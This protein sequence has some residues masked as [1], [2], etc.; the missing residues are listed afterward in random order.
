MSV[1]YRRDPERGFR[2]WH[3]N[4]VFTGEN[5][6][7]SDDLYVPNVYDVVFDG[8]NGFFRVDAVDPV[9]AVPT[10]VRFNPA[11]RFDNAVDEP[12]NLHE[13]LRLYQPHI[14]TRLFIN[15]STKPYTLSFDSRYRVYGSENTTVKLFLGTD[16]SKNGTVV[17]QTINSNGAVLSEVVDLVPLIQ[18]EVARKR[19]ARCHTT[20]DLQDGE[21]VTAVIYNAVGYASGEHSFIVRN[22]ATIAGPTVSNVYI[23]DVEL[24]SGL[25][26]NHDPLLIENQLNVPFSTSMLTCRVHYSDGSYQDM[27]VDGSRVKLHGLSNFNTS[28]LGPTTHV[29]LTYYPTS[30]EQGINL[31]SSPIPSISKTYKLANVPVDDAYAFRLY[32]VPVWEETYYWLQVR[33]TDLEY[34]MD[35]DVTDQ[36]T[37]KQANGW[38][39]NGKGFGVTQQLEMTLRLD[40]V[41]PGA[42]PGHVHVQTMNLTLNP[43][44]SIDHDNWVLDYLGD[45][46]TQF[47]SDVYAVVSSLDEKPFNISCNEATEYDWLARLYS[48][49]DPIFDSSVA[50]A[51]PLPTHFRLE[52]GGVDGR[53]EIGT[54]PVSDWDGTFYLG[55]D[56]D[57]DRRWPLNIVWLVVSNGRE[58]TLGISPLSI[59]NDI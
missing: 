33:L 17:S 10:L 59:E 21:V 31:A 3:I 26:S 9:S 40:D 13:G 55:V 20:H 15:K 19:P 44:M 16:T 57:W 46:Y 37:I 6:D 30:Q 25:I 12:D 50:E 49:L 11:A 28:L 53:W 34:T 41:M 48:S 54:Y 5:I 38:D 58:K 32:V 24:I 35:E 18:G 7:A 2:M 27:A 43:P 8:F 4:E 51:A 56:R 22:G 42:Y 52:N 36:V 45:G 47:G 1:I 39:F 23:E 29:V 14:A